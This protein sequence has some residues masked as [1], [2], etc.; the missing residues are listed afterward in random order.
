MVRVTS[1]DNEENAGYDGDKYLRII[2][3]ATKRMMD[4]FP[5]AARIRKKLLY[6]KKEEKSFYVYFYMFMIL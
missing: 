6:F 3:C 4:F 1:E 5:T 2:K